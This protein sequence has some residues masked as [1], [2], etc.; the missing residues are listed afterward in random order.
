MYGA[1]TWARVKA[2]ISR[3]TAAGMTFVMWTKEMSGETEYEI[4]TLGRF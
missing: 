2:D 3:L 4:R 1:E